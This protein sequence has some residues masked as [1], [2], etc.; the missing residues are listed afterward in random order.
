MPTLELSMIVKNGASGLARC[1]LSVQGVVDRIT[2]GDTGSTD[3][4]ELIARAHGAQVLPVEWK[5][6]F[7]MARN[8]VLARATCD[9]VLFLDADEMLD[10]K[11]VAQIPA[12]I[13]DQSVAAYEITTRN[14]VFDPGF[15]SGGEQARPNVD[16]EPET[17]NF[18]FYFTSSNTRLFRRDPGIYFE[19]CVH[20]SVADRVDALHLQRVRSGVL[21]HHF[22]Y[23]ED[24]KARRKQKENL[25][26][27]LALR[28]V[29]ECSTF[30]TYLGA[31]MAELDHAKRVSTAL[32][33][34]KKAITLS[35][36]QARG[37]L[38]AGICYT[39]I[40]QYAEA[41]N[42]MQRAICLDPTNALSFSSL[43]DIH[44]QSKG[45]VDAH[46]AYSH[47]MDLH[48]ASP[49]TLAKLGATDVHLGQHV[50]GIARIKA[51]IDRSPN[52]AELLDIYAASAF[53]AGRAIEACEAAERRLSA[54]DV[55]AFNF[56][57]AA[58][59]HVHSNLE[60]KA[61]VILRSGLLRFPDDRE[62]RNLLDS[63][64]LAAETS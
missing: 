28:K 46:V 34:F 7:A 41:L 31:G 38:Y 17:A 19:H 45:Y 4:T 36:Q 25:Y 59:L 53:L 18:P 52:E 16:D 29:S 56:L 48:D 3:E 51:A 2:I 30:G 50:P 64:L 24:T 33:F 6:N 11:A 40:G 13:D 35:P 44:F 9:W 5:N 61:K 55:T 26:Y 14:Y 23:V 8:A 10:A 20:E 57:L 1:L 39:R 27:D 15:R 58:T 32:E 63:L 60:Q 42:M 43:G 37:W 47:A 12:L 62:L 54:D 21:I 49:L 22:G